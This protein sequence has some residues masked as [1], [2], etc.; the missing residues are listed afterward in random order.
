MARSVGRAAKYVL[1]RHGDMGEEGTGRTC[2]S[3]DLYPPSNP[4]PLSLC[5][6]AHQAAMRDSLRPPN[7]FILLWA[8]IAE[9]RSKKSKMI[10]ERDSLSTLSGMNVLNE[11][12]AI[13]E[14]APRVSSV[15]YTHTSTTWQTYLVLQ[16]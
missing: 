13:C 15:P 7:P 8:A 9:R 2:V 12:L 3:H 11:S 4:L 14:S 5:S 16:P 10:L 1:A 6:N